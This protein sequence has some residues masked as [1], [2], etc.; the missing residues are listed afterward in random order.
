MK[1]KARKTAKVC[2]DITNTDFPLI[3]EI[4]VAIKNGLGIEARYSAQPAY[5]SP[6]GFPR[7]EI[8]SSTNLQEKVRESVFGSNI[9][10]ETDG[11]QATTC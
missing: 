1:E 6:D 3:E 11:R 4:R 5:L 8:L 7:K 2:L 9:N 10:H